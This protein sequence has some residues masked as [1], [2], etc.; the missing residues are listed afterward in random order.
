MLPLSIESPKIN[1]GMHICLRTAVE[2]CVLVVWAMGCVLAGSSFM[3]ERLTGLC[4]C[5]LRVWPDKLKIDRIKQ[6]LYLL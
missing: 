3:P 2:L 4:R 1:G 6:N 5:V